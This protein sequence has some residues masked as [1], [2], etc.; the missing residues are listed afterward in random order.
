MPLVVATSLSFKSL[1]TEGGRNLYNRVCNS[2]RA[3]RANVMNRCPVAAKTLGIGVSSD[4]R[5]MSQWLC[6]IG[7]RSI[8]VVSDAF[9]T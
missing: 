7:S 4:L 5:D 2:T 8:V 1:M 9:N 3:G 6:G